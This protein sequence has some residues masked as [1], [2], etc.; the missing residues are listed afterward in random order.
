MAAILVEG[1]PTAG[2]KDHVLFNFKGGKLSTGA[3]QGLK[4][5]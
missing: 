5:R 2:G 4:Q 3:G 1:G